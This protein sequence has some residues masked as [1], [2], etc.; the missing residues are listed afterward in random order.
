MPF[1][2]FS[3]RVVKAIRQRNAKSRKSQSAMLRPM[4]ETLERR[5]LLAAIISEVN[6]TG[7]SASYAADWFE[8][9]NTGPG[10]LNVSGWKMDDNSNSFG[11]AVAIRGLT[12]IP[13]GKSAVFLEDNGTGSNDTTIINSFSSAW[14]GSATPPVGLLYGFYGGSGVGLSG[15]A[16][17]VNLFDSAGVPQA[18]VSFGAATTGRTFDNAAGLNNAT[19]SQLST[20]GINGAFQSASGAETGSPQIYVDLSRYSRVGRFDLP[21]PTRTTPP[22]NS[23]LAQEASAVTYDWDTDTLF[24]VGDGGTSVVQVTKTGQLI[25]SMTL[26]PGPSP[27]GTDFY[28]TEGI[29]YV[30]GG[31]FVLVEERYRQANLFTYVAGGTLHKTDVQTVK[32]GTTIGNVGLEGLSYDPLTGGYIFVKEKD[33]ESIYQTGID[34]VAG[35]ATN[36]SPTATSSTD[37]FNPA[38]ANLADFSDVFALSNLPSLSGQ[39]DYSHLLVISQ[40]SGQIINVDRSGNVSSRLTIVADPGSPLNVPDMTMEGVTMDRNGYLYV[41]NENGGGDAHHPQL[42]V[43]APSTATNAAPTAIAL[44]NP[45]TS[46]PENTSTAAAVKVADI[47]VTDDGLG[48]NNLTVT[49]MDASSFQIIA[50]ALYLKAG[51][52]LNSIIKP[53]YSVTVNVDDTTVGNSPDASV[54]YTLNVTASTGGASSLIITEV[55]PW[56]SGNGTLGADWFEITNVGTAAQSLTGWTMDDDSSAPNIAPLS[57]I[58]SISPGESVIFIELGSG[59]TAAGDATKFRTLWASA[60]PTL[61]IGSYAGSGVGLGTGGDQ[62]NLFN[63]ITKM[64]GVTFGGSTTANPFKTFDNAAGLNWNGVSNAVISALSASGVNGAYSIPDALSTTNSTPVT[65]IGSPGTIGAAATAVVTITATD[66]N[67]AETGNNPGT[68]R[69]TRTGST[70]GA[71][72]VNYTIATGA[73]KADAADYTPALT[74]AATI[75]S[76]QSFVDITITPVTDTLVEGDEALTLTLGDSGSYDVGA[77]AAATVTIADNPFLG[78]AAGDAAASSAVLWTRVNRPQSVAVTAQVSTDAGFGGTLLTFSGTSDLTKDNTVKIAATGLTP[79]TH[80]YYRFVLDATGEISLTGNLKTA[81]DAAADV[82]LHFAFSGD[83]D[84]LIRPYAL[85]SVIPLQNLDFYINLGDVI[86]ENASNLATSGPHNGQPWLNSPSVT[87]SGSA[88]SLNGIPVGGTTFATAAQLKA[89]YEKK[90]RENFLPVNTSGQN[91]LQG[92]YA[93]QANYTTWDNHELGNRQYI[94]GGAPAG[95]SVGGPTG[96]AMATGRGVDARANGTGNPGN[97]NDAADL[98][99]PSQLAAAGGFMNDST[100]FQ[101]LENVFLAYQ[102]IA[103]RGVVSAPADPRTDGTRQLYSATPWGQNA[104]YVNTDSRS[105]RDLR[106]KTADG[107]ADDTGSRADNPNRTYLGDTQLAWLKQTLLDAQASGTTWKF[108]SLSDPIDQIGPIGGSLT[109]N[110][111][112]SFGAGS[113]YAPVNADGGKSYMGGYRAERNDLLKFIADNHINNVVFLS[114]DDHQNRINEVTY[115]PTG[116]TGVQSSYVKVPNVFSIVCGPLGATGPDLITNHTFAM[117]QQY[118]NS[119]AAAQQGA[120]VETLGLIGYPGLKNLQRDGDPTAGT[121]PQSVDF[122]SPD[123]FNFTTLDVSTDGTLTVSSVGMDA[124]TQ[125]AGIEYASGPQAHTIFSFQIDGV[126]DAPS[127][128]LAN[129]VTSLPEDTSTA[130]HFKVAD[131]NVTD[132]A[133]GTNVLSLSG[134]DASSFELVGNALYLKAGTTLNFEAKASYAMTVNVDDATVGSTPDAFVDFTLGVT[135]V[136][137]APT[138][139]N[140]TNVVSSLPENTSTATRIKVADISVTDDALGTNVLSLSGADA[141]SFELD[142]NA[143]YLKLGTTLNFEVKPS[144]AVKVN[145]DDATVGSTPDAFAN[146]ALTVIDGNNDQPAV[147]VGSDPLHPGQSALF[148]V[149][150]VHDDQ[151]TAVGTDGGIWRVEIESHGPHSEFDRAYNGPFSRIVVYGLAGDDHI[152]V[153][154]SSPTEAW[155]LGGAGND[156]LQGGAGLNLL[157]GGTGDDHLQAGDGLAL[158]IGGLGSD[159]LQGGRGEDILIG[160]TTDYDASDAA[161][162][163]ILAEWNAAGA[164]LTRIANLQGSSFAYRLT[165]STVHDDGSGD[166]LQ[167]GEG[168]DW[169]FAHLTGNKNEKDKVD[170]PKKGEVLI[171][172]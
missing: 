11:S 59:H 60:P 102:P 62:V 119:I 99:T 142:G 53:S 126:N 157:M 44:I 5:E 108:V 118:S 159:H 158:L 83:N 100:G 51:T 171:S 80:Y 97:V 105:Y 81:P 104:I 52:T 164:Y 141:S 79:G 120:G 123:T 114:T 65:V 24:V 48:V 137:E 33:P 170:G 76:G 8:V 94:N 3:R 63:G 147:F 156:H 98:F 21:E 128:G 136:N 131:I 121:S 148:V 2:K 96:T 85:A 115:S 27:Q 16:D 72:T 116:D 35:T 87:L 124:T 30:G 15:T 89:D 91:S 163:A 90:Y 75:P 111:L 144:Y 43:Y 13:A 47:A 41:V 152:E 42:W 155:L 146:F 95:G 29:T 88:S 113:T 153:D 70:V 68:F 125:N 112:P 103:D 36:G 14:F 61:K 38:L 40:E 166:H 4:L 92:L 172:I 139:V 132:D 74:G 151:I 145:V 71:L 55:A 56:S 7:S 77:P 135:D 86:Y 167:G 154:D 31:K 122:Y 162:G 149:G 18:S 93:A 20:V 64:A 34:F 143:L 23:L 45:V 82:P 1:Q 129:T 69:I 49:G 12:N 150:T 6:P 10:D 32:L 140:L 50:T 22:A 37:L 9:T 160:G 101:T 58:S 117:A 17:A 66:A 46:I 106:L 109:L 165:S 26:A 54:N 57:G 168:L 39:T 169:Y 19:I 130:V 127:I 110:N 25:N 73:G 28:D 138:A 84:G 133:L 134:A 67:A 107:S 161:L 78:V